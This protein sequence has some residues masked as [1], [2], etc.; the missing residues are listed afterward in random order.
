MKM[1]HTKK[2][3][4]INKLFKMKQFSQ[5]FLGKGLFVSIKGAF[6]K[7]KGHL[8]NLEGQVEIKSTPS[9]VISDTIDS[10]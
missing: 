3:W 7:K 6:F 4:K 2:K 8:A 10:N 5:I 1:L 9:E